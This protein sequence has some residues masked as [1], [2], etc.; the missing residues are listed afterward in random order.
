MGVV[1]CWPACTDATIMEVRTELSEANLSPSEYTIEASP[2][3]ADAVIAQVYAEAI[4]AHYRSNKT[5]TEFLAE[6]RSQ[7][8]DATRRDGRCTC[9]SFSG[10]F[11]RPR[12][13]VAVFADDDAR[14]HR[15]ATFFQRPL[16]ADQKINKFTAG[17][18]KDLL[19]VDARAKNAECVMWMDAAMAAYG[20]RKMRD[21]EVR[22]IDFSRKPKGQKAKGPEGFVHPD[23]YPPAAVL[24]AHHNLDML[25]LMSDSKQTA[26]FC[27]MRF[28]VPQIAYRYA[29]AL[30]TL[31]PK[32]KS[33]V[34]L[35]D[36]AALKT[37]VSNDRVELP[38]VD[39][40]SPE[41]L[42]LFSNPAARNLVDRYRAATTALVA[43]AC[44][45]R[46]DARF[47]ITWTRSDAEA[48]ALLAAHARV[49][50]A[51]KRPVFPVYFGKIRCSQGDAGVASEGG[52]DTTLAA[53][54]LSKP[55]PEKV[56]R[57]VIEVAVA[58]LELWNAKKIHQDL[59]ARSVLLAGDNS[60]VRLSAVMS[61]ADRPTKP[62]KPSFPLAQLG[63]DLEPALRKSDV[64]GRMRAAKS[65]KDIKDI[66]QTLKSLH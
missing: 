52:F 33:D 51:V 37:L 25:S 8:S 42:S 66:I 28:P 50:D 48:D 45:T 13:N 58:A 18:I 19:A 7:F 12:E 35:L 26:F 47:A 59:G 20:L 23:K 21:G 14:A 64:C 29:R 4:V 15:L 34:A 5:G 16:L 43:S 22:A 38:F 55:A 6:Q 11:N 10:R 2:A 1:L 24:R 17:L 49:A 32:E 53:W 60:I 46:I 54:L 41:A 9:F 27:G 56:Y 31:P 30:C 40:V 39:A 57:V 44:A 65:A 36:A 63:K 3:T 62:T 61:V